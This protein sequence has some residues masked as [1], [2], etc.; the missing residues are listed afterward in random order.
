MVCVV[1]NSVAKA[2]VA[3]VT[4]A[5]WYQGTSHHERRRSRSHL[6]PAF[7]RRIRVAAQASVAKQG[8][9]GTALVVGSFQVPP[10]HRALSKGRQFP[11]DAHRPFLVLVRV[12]GPGNGGNA[13]SHNDHTELRST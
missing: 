10:R 6:I 4:V 2:V 11:C 7:G 5:S 13:T 1:I 9:S 12:L 3:A 8:R